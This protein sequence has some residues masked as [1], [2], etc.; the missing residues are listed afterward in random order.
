MRRILC[1][2]ACVLGLGLMAG[3][4]RADECPVPDQPVVPVA[5]H[6]HY[7][8]HS[9]GRGYHRGAGHQYRYHAYRRHGYRGAGRRYHR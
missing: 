3:A 8:P 2:A 1:A 5:Y 6:H 4:A 7:R 9:V